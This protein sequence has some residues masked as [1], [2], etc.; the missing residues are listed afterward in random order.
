MNEI[1]KH[2]PTPLEGELLTEEEEA[3]MGAGHAEAQYRRATEIDRLAGFRAL[4]HDEI[5]KRRTE[6]FSSMGYLGGYGDL[7]Q[8]AQAQQA[9][10]GPLSSE[11]FEQWVNKQ[12]ENKEEKIREIEER[13]N[14]E[15]F[16][17]FSKLIHR[18]KVCLVFLTTVVVTTIVLNKLF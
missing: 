11:H 16:D 9:Q 8:G 7:A 10:Q 15:K 13:I 12:R 5:T 18:I 1:T 17:E 14:A 2:K 4:S 3:A 6:A